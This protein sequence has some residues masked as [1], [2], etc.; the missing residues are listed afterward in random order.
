MWEYP[1]ETQGS[2][3]GAPVY[4]ST[5]LEGLHYDW[6]TLKRELA[7]DRGG[8]WTKLW[9][10]TKP[11]SQNGDGAYYFV[12]FYNQYGSPRNVSDQ[13]S[14]YPLNTKWDRY[15][16]LRYSYS[17]QGDETDRIHKLNMLCCRLSV[18][19]KYCVE[20][21]H[22]NAPSTYEWRTYSQCPVDEYQGERVVRDYFYLGPN[23]AIDDYIIDMSK[24]WKIANNITSNMGLEGEGLAIPVKKSDNLNGPVKFEI[25]GA[26][27]GLWKD[28]IRIHPSFW[29]HTR[30]EEE[31]RAILANTQYILLKDLT[32]EIQ[33]DNGGNEAIE[34]E[35][36]LIYQTVENTKYISKMDDLTFELAT[37]LTVDEAKEKGT[38]TLP[39]T[40]APYVGEEALRSLY[41]TV[42]HNTGKAEELY[43]TDYY[44]EYCTPQTLVETTLQ[45]LL[46]WTS[47]Y[48]WPEV[49]N[50]WTTGYDYQVK[51]AKT[52]VRT[53][54]IEDNI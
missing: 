35:K 26:V 4:T 15:A 17:A 27:N 40:N 23:P 19:D 32:I 16:D 43:L 28:I 30:W 48:T 46:P 29:R 20:I 33:S 7:A 34:E 10:K 13:E 18:G 25:L 54:H 52:L 6:P 41:N 49:G 51:R 3:D 38:N 37:L 47:R 12:K 50:T 9:H 36:D 5:P 31:T 22:N 11:I 53:K 39:K 24:S 14:I 42:T 44:R 45:G 8:L 2:V 1:N 21:F